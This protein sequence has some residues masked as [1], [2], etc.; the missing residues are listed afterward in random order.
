ME[1]F[2][3]ATQYEIVSIDAHAY[4]FTNSRI[5][6]S[7]I[8]DGLFAYD[9]ADANDGC[10][11]RVQKHVM[12]SHWGTIIGRHELALNES[13]RYYPEIGSDE[14][15]GIYFAPMNYEEYMQSSEEK[16]GIDVSLK[17]ICEENLCR[18]G[19]EYKATVHYDAD[20]SLAQRII[21]TVSDDIPY[22]GLKVISA[23]IQEKEN[24]S[25]GLIIE[26]TITCKEDVRTA[27]AR[28]AFMNDLSVEMGVGSDD[29]IEINVRDC[30]I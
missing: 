1:K 19:V 25:D 29:I 23:E 26:Y 3:A 17:E 22:Y 5:D 21:D 4:M 30:D 15:E 28:D 2:N 18:K 16:I 6:R 24:K 27:Y 8:P 10:F 14:Y 12:V 13:G 7:T 11:T 20:M 9:V